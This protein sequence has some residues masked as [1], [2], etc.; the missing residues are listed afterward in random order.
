MPRYQFNQFRFGKDLKYWRQYNELTQEDAAVLFGVSRGTV[1]GWEN[2]YNA[3][4]I[5]GN[6][7]TACEWMD[8]DPRSYF[9]HTS[10]DIPF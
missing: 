5:I 3:G 1:C 6:L 7:L 10:D 8:R 9:V 2:G 4:L